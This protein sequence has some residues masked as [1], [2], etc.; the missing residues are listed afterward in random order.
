MKDLVLKG[1]L[2]TQFEE[3]MELSN[4]SDLLDLLAADTGDIP[5]NRY[6]AGFHCKG[7]VRNR[8]GNVRQSSDFAVEIWFPSD[9]LR[10]AD[11]FKT[12]T[13]LGPI[14]VWHPNI[15]PPAIC[16]GK[17]APGTELVDLLYR[18][19]DIIRY[20][21]WAAHDALNASAAQ[22]ARNHQDRFPV[23]RRPLKRRALDLK[24]IDNANSTGV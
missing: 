9:Y 4:Q 6:I 24:V 11:P 20:Y 16:V 3:G 2:R 15:H 10:R 18:C 21:N 12:L 5:P 22:W 7:L 1:F 14:D 19:Y 8:D 13:W 17:I 23:D